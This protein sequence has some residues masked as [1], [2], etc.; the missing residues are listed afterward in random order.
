MAPGHRQLPPRQVDICRQAG[1]DDGTRQS[2]GRAATDPWRLLPP[3]EIE[4]GNI[5]M[6]L[7]LGPV[8]YYWD[9]DTML[10]FYDEMADA[11]VDIIYLGETVCSRRHLLRLQDY[12]DMAERLSAAGQGGGGFA[13]PP[14]ATPQ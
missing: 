1:M 4:Y 8:L 10:S 13:P 12:L 3:L 14:L 11:P 9:R 5:Q 2:L 7:A 6:K